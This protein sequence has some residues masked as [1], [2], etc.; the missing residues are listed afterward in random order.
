MEGVL[1]GSTTHQGAPG[2]PGPPWCL[3]GS[4]RP[5]WCT[6]WATWVSSMQKKFVK[7]F[8][9]FG[10]RLVLIFLEVKNKQKK[11]LTLGNMS[12]G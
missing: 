5:L 4:T 6:S 9:A 11:Q 7:N 8:I 12:I 1:V 3:V 10:L 2:G